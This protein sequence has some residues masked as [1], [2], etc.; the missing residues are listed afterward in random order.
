[1]EENHGRAPIAFSAFDIAPRATASIFL[2]L[3]H[4]TGAALLSRHDGF[5]VC[6]AIPLCL[7]LGD[8]FFK[9]VLM[10]PR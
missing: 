3:R 8:Y 4:S 9:Q 5:R 7:H 10:R 6:L 2:L 1:M